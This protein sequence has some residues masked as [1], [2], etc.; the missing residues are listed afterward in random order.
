MVPLGM[1]LGATVGGSMGDN[2]AV[3]IE[4]FMWEVVRTGELT[5]FATGTVSDFHDTWNLDANSN[6]TPQDEASV[7]NEGFWELDGTNITPTDH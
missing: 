3:V 6:Y 2:V 5:P 1:G 4:D 7:S